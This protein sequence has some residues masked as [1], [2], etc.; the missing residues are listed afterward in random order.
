MRG[1]QLL[2]WNLNHFAI[3]GHQAIDFRFDVGGLRIDACGY[4]LRSQRIQLLNGSGVS[5]PELR[6]RFW[7]SAV[8]PN[9]IVGVP[10]VIRYWISVPAKLSHY[11][12][13]APVATFVERILWMGIFVMIHN[14]TYRPKITTACD[15]D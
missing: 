13:K 6:L 12:D 15:V 11:F 10:H 3:V 4:P 8:S 5:F 2:G 9:A 14:V 1:C 7:Q